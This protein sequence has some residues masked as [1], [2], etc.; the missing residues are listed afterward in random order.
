[1]KKK[2]IRI[3]NNRHTHDAFGQGLDI[4]QNIKYIV[5]NCDYL[6]IKIWNI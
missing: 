4:S 1:M 6:T 2:V 5:S 3:F